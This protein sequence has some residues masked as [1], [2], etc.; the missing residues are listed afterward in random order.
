M[1]INS[2]LDFIKIPIFTSRTP[3]ERFNSVDLQKKLSRSCPPRRFQENR[4]PT[5]PLAMLHLLL[6]TL[7]SGV[8]QL[9]CC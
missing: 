7:S 1:S 3:L 4:A 5:V 2:D 6:L 8:K 9:C